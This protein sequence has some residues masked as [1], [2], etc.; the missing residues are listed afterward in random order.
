MLFP[1]DHIQRRTM[2]V[3]Q[4]Y[5]LIQIPGWL[6]AALVL[7]VLRKWIDFP[8]WAVVLVLVGFIVK[9][10]VVFPFVRRAYES[11]ENTGIEQMVGASGITKE[12]LD[13]EGYVQ[14]HGELWRAEAESQDRPIPR[15]RPIRVISVRGYRLVVTPHLEN[16]GA[17]SS[18]SSTST[19]SAARMD[20]RLR[21]K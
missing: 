6:L 12:P 16:Q 19:T 2:R 1:L 18:V 10:F 11:E 17:I 7:F 3:W 21:L 14:I 20:S 5:L 13:P 4:K 9:D 15:R 8:L